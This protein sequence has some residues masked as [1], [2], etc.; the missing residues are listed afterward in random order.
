MSHFIF[1]NAIYLFMAVLGLCCCVGFSLV[2]ASGD[3]S[4]LQG[5]S[6]SLCG[7]LMVVGSLVAEHRP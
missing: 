3:S 5:A 1:Y 2:M 4:S 6:F 7:L